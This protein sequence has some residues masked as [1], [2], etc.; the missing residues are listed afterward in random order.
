MTAFTVQHSLFDLGS[1]FTQPASPKAVQAPQWIA[2]NQTLAEQLQL[3]A[4]LHA[5]QTGLSVWSGNHVPE[6]AKPR[7]HAYAGHQFGNLVPQLGDGRALLLAEIIDKHGKHWDVQLK[8]A[9]PTPFSR[10]GDG[11]SA[12]GPVLR[13]YLL[14]ESMFVLGVPTTRALAAVASGELVFRDQGGVPGAVFTRVASSHL[15][16]GSFQFASLHGGAEKVKQLA[17]YAIARHYPELQDRTGIERYLAFLHA[18]AMK[19]AELI[20]QWLRVGFIHGVMNTDNT[21]ICGETIDYGP[22][23]FLDSYHPQKVFSSIDRRGRYAFSSQPAIAQWNLARL[24]ECLLPLL[25]VAP[26]SNDEASAKAARENAIAVATRVLDEYSAR[27]QALWLS[28]MASK[29]GIEHAQAEDD[30]L[31]QDFLV[32]LQTHDVDYTQAFWQLANELI[33]NSGESA[34]G[35]SVLVEPTAP[36]ASL[37]A[38]PDDYLAW[39]QRWLQRLSDNQRSVHDTVNAMRSVNPA[40]IPRNHRIAEAITEVEESGSLK[41]FY[42]LLNA[43]KTPYH[44]PTS[45]LELELYQAPSKAEEVQRTFCGT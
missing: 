36:A 43:W 20:S 7:A 2:F 29:M 25:T 17:D 37:F 16:I 3:P 40:L 33:E 34:S 27:A 11:R 42:T 30:T 38:K 12:I 18:V 14:S 32:V 35:E 9:G 10:G 5:T 19:Q 26:E 24:A 13:E 4:E 31:I 21:S 39:R 15:R 8:G 44:M 41:R 1:F 6:W 28:T 45:E 23:A 22:A